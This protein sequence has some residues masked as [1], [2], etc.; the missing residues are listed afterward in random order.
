MNNLGEYKSYPLSTKDFAKNNHSATQT[1]L[2][3][4]CL[5]GS[6]HGVRPLKLA[7]GRLAWPNV[8]VS[9]YGIQEA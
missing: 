9:I 7:S 4:H 8:I 1:V 6:F 5:T 2:K 3:N